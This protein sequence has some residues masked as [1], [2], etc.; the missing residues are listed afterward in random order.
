MLRLENDL[1]ERGLLKE[2]K[3]GEGS[4]SV[5]E[6]DSLLKEGLKLLD[7]DIY[8]FLKNNSIFKLFNV[9]IYPFLRYAPWLVRIVDRAASKFLR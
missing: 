6:S 3:A 7:K 2:V 9:C 5:I 8:F 1:K 4:I